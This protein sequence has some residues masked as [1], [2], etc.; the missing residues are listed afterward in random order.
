L[1]G[2]FP[3]TKYRARE[4][5]KMRAILEIGSLQRP[6]KKLDFLKKNLPANRAAKKVSGTL[7]DCGRTANAA[8]ATTA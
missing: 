8:H 6:D 4:V 7:A 3:S 5:G 1:S 2:I